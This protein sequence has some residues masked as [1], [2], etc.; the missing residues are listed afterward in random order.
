MATETQKSL[1]ATEILWD[2][3]VL[4]PTDA[5]TV[6]TMLAAVAVE[7]TKYATFTADSLQ[8]TYGGSGMILIN[9][10]A[11]NGVYSDINL[12]TVDGHLDDVT[13]LTHTS[14]LESW[15]YSDDTPIT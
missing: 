1:R 8:Y 5:A 9:N 13:L 15:A 7:L 6:A 2:G 12:V 3:A 4:D 10:A 14:V 11:L